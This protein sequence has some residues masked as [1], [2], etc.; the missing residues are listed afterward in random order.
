MERL[1]KF[2]FKNTNSRQTIA[3]NMFW[4]FTSEGMSRVLKVAFVV[5]ATRVL[6]AEGWGIFSYALSLGSLLMIFSDIGLSGL[7]TRETVQKKEGFQNFITTALVL[8]SILAVL[9][10]IAVVFIG[11][12]V[13]NLPGAVLLLPLIALTLFFD[14]VRDL[15]LYINTAFEKMERD[16]IAKMTM[17]IT[18]I[19]VGVLL[20]YLRPIPQSLAIGY[21]IGSA[22]GCA[23][24]FW[25]VWRD[26]RTVF[27]R[28]DRALLGKVVQTTLPFAA[29][30]LINNV[31]ANTDIYLLGMWRNATEIG[32]YASA[33]RIYQFILMFPVMFATALF[34]LLSRLATNDDERFATILGKTTALVFLIGLPISIGG[35]ILAPNIIHLLFGAGFASAV[36]MLQI[37]LVMI[38]AA[39]PLVLFS[40]SVFA[41]NGQTRLAIIYSVGMVGNALCNMLLIPSLGAVGSAIAT[42][43]STSLITVLVWKRLYRMTRFRV[44]THLRRTVVALIF[45][46]IALGIMK[47][48]GVPFVFE[49]LGAV[50]VYGGILILFREP[51][52]MEIKTLKSSAE[53]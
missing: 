31:M 52:L 28:F 49:I 23:F 43:V 45:M 22:V 25:S 50:V 6:G 26:I 4:L 29:I 32:L 27:G 35:I 42:L 36:P 11:P 18:T 30:S 46:V 34:P 47:S 3:K 40:N 14:V 5:Y 37:L 38:I 44:F 8:K 53:A 24:A 19:G 33:Q 51:L 48:A 1:K 13:S 2:L 16:M 9:S 17:S 20:L 39:F 15:V 12:L 21:A 7:I 41:Y 10:T